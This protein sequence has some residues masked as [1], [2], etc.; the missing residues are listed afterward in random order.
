MTQK[1]YIIAEAGVNHNGDLR[2]AKQMIAVAKDCGADAIKFQM[3]QTESLCAVDAPLAEYQQGLA[4]DSQNLLKALELSPKD[5]LFL[6][7]ECEKNKIDFLVTPFDLHSAKFL[8]DDLHC[9]AVKISS[10]D[11]TD[12]QLLYTVG[13][14]AQKIYLSTGMSTLEQ[15]ERSLCVLAAAFLKR[16]YDQT[17]F[18]F[19]LAE[20]SK[21]LKDRV[22]ILHC[23]SSYPAADDDLNLNAISL[24]REKFSLDV[25]YSDHSV[26]F[27]ASVVAVSLGAS[28]IEKHFT[29]DQSL[30]GPDHKASLSPYDLKKLAQ[31]IRRTELQLGEAK[32]I[33]TESE[34]S[35]AQ[36]A[37]KGLYA[38]RDLLSG[39]RLQW[40]DVIGLRPVNK[41]KADQ[42]SEVLN[43]P[44]D[45]D[46][47]KGE[48]L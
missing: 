42:L 20:L 38:S 43:Q 30:K 21:T 5:F 19:S 3:F 22:V 4:E 9:T 29:L 24:L 39:T 1:T 37:R 17:I 8:L 14:K 28:V 23:T 12:H 15:I 36:V 7:E 35:N 47:K 31:L 25:G 46:L 13:T 41:W 33:V 48:P 16:D 32:K 27:L 18:N 2:F 44:I 6:K 26:D 11:L 34:Q 40:D 45:R 10:G